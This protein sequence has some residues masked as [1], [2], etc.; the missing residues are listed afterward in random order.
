MQVDTL[1]TARWIIPVEPEGL[2]LER[3]AI[4]IDDGRILEVL[5]VSQA[6][7]QYQPRHLEEFPQH[8][9][10]PGFVNAHTHAAMTLMRGVAN[11]L[12]LMDWLQ[13]HIWPLEQRWVSEG[14]VRDGSDLAMAEMIRG[15][16][17]CFND[18]YFYPDV[19]ARRA[20][21]VGMR[22]TVGLIV[23]DFPT[24]WGS[25]PDEYFSRGLALFDE[26]RNS[27]PLVQC[28]FAPH[29]PYTV[30]DQPLSRIHTLAAE[31]NLPVHIHLHET[32]DE[33]EKSLVSH[34]MRPL[35]RLQQLGLLGPQLISVHMTQLTD[36]EIALLAETGVS[37]VHCPESNMKLASGFCPVARL[38][39]A[40]VNV[41]L[42]TDGAA[43][44]NDLDLMG[45]M[46]TAALL[47]KVVS[48]N[49]GAVPAARA[50]SMATLNGAKALGLEHE[51]GSLVPGKS[52][53]IA[54][55]NLNL[56]ENQPYHDPISDLVYSA[57]RHQISDV[58]VA[59]RRLL[60]NREL[61]TLDSAEILARCETWLDR[62]STAQPSV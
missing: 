56:L 7:A 15:G 34:G 3:H 9:L 11:D 21:A 42:G 44:N 19:T 61:T 58:W 18:M 39:E 51:I 29:A 33:T 52:A 20:V 38:L 16:I 30:S 22:A 8:A 35:K 40:N 36:A 10:F 26:L 57:S 6:L 54:A 45:E 13:N 50:L 49:A 59:G 55:I 17:T 28:C 37:V 43:S 2:V 53:D 62:L 60:K 27:T 46:R 47:A 5:P 24:A 41:A 14:F 12:P 48:G 32:A 23:V 1:I 25:G 4:V 31:L